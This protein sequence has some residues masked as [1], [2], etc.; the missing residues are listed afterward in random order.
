MVGK[1]FCSVFSTVDQRQRN[2]AQQFDYV[3]QMI[4][5]ARVIVTTVR[6]K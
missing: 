2:D 3:R 6:I 5:V 1:I 4:F